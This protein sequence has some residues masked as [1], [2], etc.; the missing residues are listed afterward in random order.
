MTKEEV[1]KMAGE[2]SLP[3]PEESQEICFLPDQDYRDFLKK[4]LGD[5][6]PSGGD[7]V[8]ANGRVLGRHKGIHAY[9]IGQR[10]GLGIPASEP[11]YVLA[12]E[13]VTNRVVLGFKSQTRARRIMVRDLVFSAEPPG[14]EFTALVQIRSRHKPARAMVTVLTGDRAEIDFEE[15]QASVAPGQAAAVYDG[16]RLLGGGWILPP[17][18]YKPPPEPA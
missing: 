12:M 6:L 16:R 7:F 17:T 9:T 8:D 18:F 14:R 11:Y 13:P 10:R 5:R 4:R 15:P 2:L 1:R 3:I